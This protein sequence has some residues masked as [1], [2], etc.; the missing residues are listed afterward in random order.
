M[1]NSP[2]V[3]QAAHVSNRQLA[4][5]RQ[6]DRTRR[7]T[8]TLPPNVR[9]MDNGPQMRTESIL[10]LFS[11]LNC[12]PSLSASTTQFETARSPIS[13]LMR[14]NQA[15]NL[16]QN[17]GSRGSCVCARLALHAR[18]VPSCPNSCD[19]PGCLVYVKTASQHHV[20]RCR[21]L[22]AVSAATLTVLL[23]VPAVLAQV[24]SID[25][26]DAGVRSAQTASLFWFSGAD[27]AHSRAARVGL[28]KPR[29]RRQHQLAVVSHA[30]V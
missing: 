9:K 6:H 29:A 1:A 12:S 16:W 2:K 8:A 20:K 24:Q 18:C 3:K 7:M 10:V 25:R 30:A 15:S 22:S 27:R 5:C 21:L 11:S 28:V 13:L 4:K 23:L 14:G 26:T 19:E 17:R